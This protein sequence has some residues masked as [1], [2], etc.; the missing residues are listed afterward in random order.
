M[1]K[2]DASTAEVPFGKRM[3]TPRKCKID[4]R[5]KDIQKPEK[6]ELER[7]EAK[8]RVS[9]PPLLGVAQQTAAI[10]VPRQNQGII[11]AISKQKKL[12]ES[13]K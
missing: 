6:P 4:L 5:K 13:A 10:Q 7:K 11:S 2:P 12:T 1:S 8:S 3:S 9:Q